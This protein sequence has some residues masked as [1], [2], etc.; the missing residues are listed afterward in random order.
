MVWQH[1]HHCIWKDD[2]TGNEKNELERLEWASISQLGN[3]VSSQVTYGG[4]WAR[5]R[6]KVER[7]RW[8]CERL[9]SG[10][11]AE[12]DMSLIATSL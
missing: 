4:N 7:N 10:L 6:V 11:R 8:I 3:Q 5:V 9:K 1:E 12:L 2:L